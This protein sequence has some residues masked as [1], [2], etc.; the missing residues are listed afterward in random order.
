MADFETTNFFA[1]RSVHDDPYPY[2]DHL[3]ELSPIWQE[4]HY[5]VYMVSG[6]SLIHI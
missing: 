3:R 5:G 6:L 2:F 4:P 1:D